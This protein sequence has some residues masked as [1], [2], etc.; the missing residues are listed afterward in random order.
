MTNKTIILSVIGSGF[1]QT[2]DTG[3]DEQ[4]QTLF[5]N[6]MEDGSLIQITSWGFRHIP[7]AKGETV[8]TVKF[9]GKIIKGVARGTQMVIAMYGG[10]LFYYELDQTGNIR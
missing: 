3:I 1:A 8:K 10:D 5:I 7:K 9:D 6:R 2:K 4:S